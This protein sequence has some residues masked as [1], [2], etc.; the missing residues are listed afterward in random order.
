[1]DLVEDPDDNME[2]GYELHVAQDDTWRMDAVFQS[3]E[4]WEVI[5]LSTK[6]SVSCYAHYICAV[7]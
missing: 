6:P 3:C 1:M 5:Y 7:H 4:L 2:R